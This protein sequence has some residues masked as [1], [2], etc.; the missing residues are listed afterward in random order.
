M[1]MPYLLLVTDN[2]DYLLVYET[3]FWRVVLAPKF[4]VLVGRCIVQ[5][6]DIVEM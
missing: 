1:P 2:Q 6:K 4:N 3:A 5:L